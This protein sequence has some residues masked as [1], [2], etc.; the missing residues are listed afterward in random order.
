MKHSFSF[1]ESLS[2]KYRV[3]KKSHF[4][5]VIFWFVS[6]RM[7]YP[8]FRALL[9]FRLPRVSDGRF[10][11]RAILYK[12]SNCCSGA[13]FDKSFYNIFIKEWI[14]HCLQGW[15]TSLSNFIKIFNVWV[16]QLKTT[17]TMLCSIFLIFI[18]FSYSL[19][20]VKFITKQT[21]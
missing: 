10:S 5:T 11:F 21:N 2:R 7:R 15:N 4:T 16:N 19:F 12:L 1:M 9:I 17:Q 3:V 18:N 8:K 20:N 6:Y 14:F 13:I